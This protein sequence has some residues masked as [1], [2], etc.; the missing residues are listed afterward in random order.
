MGSGIKINLHSCVK[1]SLFPSLRFAFSMFDYFIYIHTKTPF[2]SSWCLP[3]RVAKNSDLYLSQ[4]LVRLE[5]LTDY[6]FFKTIFCEGRKILL[7][8]YDLKFDWLSKQ[9]KLSKMQMCCFFENNYIFINNSFALLYLGD[10]RKYHFFSRGFKQALKSGSI[11]WVK[12]SLKHTQFNEW[13]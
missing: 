10:Q 13:K 4:H 1:L 8:D 5:S 9:C 2:F 11:W 3:R 7:N 12:T 6:W